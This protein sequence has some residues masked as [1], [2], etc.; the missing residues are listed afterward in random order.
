MSISYLVIAFSSY[1]GGLE[2]KYRIGWAMVAFFL[3]NLLCNILF[4]FYQALKPLFLKINKKCRR[5]HKKKSVRFL[6]MAEYTQHEFLPSS[7]VVEL[8]EKK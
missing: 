3:F 5:K 4:I 7:P 6:T 1:I 8:P 2:L